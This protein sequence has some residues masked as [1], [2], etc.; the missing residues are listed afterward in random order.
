MCCNPEIMKVEASAD[1]LRFAIEASFHFE[2]FNDQELL[3]ILDM[4]LRQQDLDATD[5]AKEVALEV[6]SRARNRPNFGNAGEVENQLSLAKGRFQS[7]Q[8]SQKDTGGSCDVVFAPQDFDADYMRGAR[9]A[10]NLQ[11]LFEGM[12]GC[13]DVIEKLGNYQKLA[14]GL[15]AR[16]QDPRETVPT[17]FLFKGP[18]G[19]LDVT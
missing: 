15:K 5:E 2:D 19:K 14:Q 11:S 3:E 18:P 12:I 13:E 4:K 6:L 16:G 7:R 17:N 9:A 8:S 10:T 1:R